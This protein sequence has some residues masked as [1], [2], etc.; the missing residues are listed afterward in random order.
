MES[1]QLDSTLGQ[2]AVSDS[3]LFSNVFLASLESLEDAGI[4]FWGEDFLPGI[5]M[6]VRVFEGG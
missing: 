1:G 6:L 5:G 4:H 2:L 3:E